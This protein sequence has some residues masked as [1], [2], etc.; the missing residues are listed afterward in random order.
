MKKI[1]L[2]LAC[3]LCC[4]LMVRAQAPKLPEKV[5]AMC[6]QILDGTKLP[7]MDE[8]L[9]S[10][11]TSGTNS[12]WGQDKTVKKLWVV[13]SDRADNPTYTDSKKTRKLGTLNFGQEVCIA[14]IVG[15]MALVYEDSRKNFPNIP[16]TISSKGWVPM[17]KLLLWSKCPTD[18]RGVQLKALIA[19]NL[20][21]TSEKSKF[22]SVKLQNPDEMGKSSAISMDMNYYYI[23][24][25]TPDQEWALLCTGA[26]FNQQ[27]L[28]GWVHK[29]AYTIW[30]QRT[31]LE[32]N[33]LTKYVGSHIGGKTYVYDDEGRSKIV[34]EW[35]FGNKNNDNDE[36]YQYRMT[37]S[38]L[39]FPVLG[40]ANDNG[41]IH[42]TAFA[43]K[44]GSANAA[45]NFENVTENVNRKRDAMRQMNVIL[46]VEASAMMSKF[47]P[48]IKDALATCSDYAKQGL[49]V[50]VGLVLYR[51]SPTGIAQS[52]VIPLCNYND[53]KLM[54]K[55]QASVAN[56][57][58][59][60]EQNVSL[61]QAIETAANGSKMG[62]QKDQSNLVLLVGYHGTDE[63]TWQEENLLKTLKSNDIQLASIQIMRNESGSCARYLDLIESLVKK[64]VEAQY[65]SIGAEAKFSLA[66]NNDGYLF[67]SS[68]K[69]NDNTNYNSQFASVRFNPTMKQEMQP[70]ELTKYIINA[71][72][73]FSKS[74]NNKSVVLEKSLANINFYPEFLMKH[75][76]EKEYKRWETQKAISAYSG[77]ARIKDLG[78]NDEWRPI[79]YL[80]Y[81]E[82]KELIQNLEG[83]SNAQK[84][85]NSDR[86]IFVNAI[87]ELLKKQLGGSIS[88]KEIQELKT[89]ELE[90]A[91]YGIV[92]IP[93][94]NMR[95]TKHSLKDL[96]NRKVVSDEEYFDILDNFNK[97]YQ[98]LKG[99]LRGY[100]YCLEV[101]NEKGAKMRYYWI[102]L[103][104]LP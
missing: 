7:K 100:K 89:E 46:A 80:S 92:N 104:D 101:G 68:K 23:M 22:K 90:N 55:L 5:R 83:V 61:A 36:M 38:L 30:N 8:D 42:C 16:T 14:E 19:I 21:K 84:T 64:N 98:K 24:K 34:T 15:D 74:I 29:T 70:S 45:S 33:W 73:G 76:G 18:T 4:T 93:S 95:F 62:F 28:Y 71:I 44:T 88:D 11:F 2:F 43:D 81:D 20:N 59:T 99:Y 25:E 3:I 12:K 41:M 6:P 51:N 58:L 102:P 27:T 69:D 57:R 78:D 79:I 54:S 50:Q 56:T 75:L 17:D 60:G 10:R 72:N 91:I 66:K 49:N 1:L 32:P 26:D 94:E 31:C 39:R 87:K 40:K 96:M 53:A 37:P 77:Y 103:E 85:R 82:L 48:A 67:S 13:Y 65:K 86:N 9:Y 52:D 35:E 63:K 97:K 47:F